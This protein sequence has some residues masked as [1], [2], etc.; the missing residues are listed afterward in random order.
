[1]MTSRIKTVWGRASA[2]P[3]IGLLCLMLAIPAMAHS[4]YTALTRLNYNSEAQTIEVIHRL[5]AHDMEAVLSFQEKQVM[6]FEKDAQLEGLA[7]DYLIRHFTLDIDGK[8]IPLQFIGLEFSGEDLIGYFEG[9]LKAAPQKIAITNRIFIDELPGQINTLVATIGEK[10]GAARF[11]E[12]E[13]HKIV[14]FP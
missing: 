7:G 9:P 14:D 11:S 8:A 3:L 6:S 5:A 2:L 13:T 12:G 4:F 1:M 10:T